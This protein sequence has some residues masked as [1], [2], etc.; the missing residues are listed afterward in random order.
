M[1][2]SG[3]DNPKVKLY[4]KLYESKKARGETGLFVA[5]GIIN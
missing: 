3:K 2:I 1:L 5:E 4:R